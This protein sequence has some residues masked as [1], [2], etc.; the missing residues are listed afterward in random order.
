MSVTLRV[1]LIVMSVLTSLYVLIQIR[2]SRLKIEDSTFWF[3]LS[4][5]LVIIG[6]FPQIVEFGTKLFGIQSPV[7]FVFLGIIFILIVKLFSLTVRVSQLENKVENL[8]QRYAIDK[9]K[10]KVRKKE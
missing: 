5:V 7:N 10:E 1:L 4:A 2:K 3:L 9:N 6:I 8:A